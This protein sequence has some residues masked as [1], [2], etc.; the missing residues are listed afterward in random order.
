MIRTTVRLDKIKRLSDTSV[1][2]LKALSDRLGDDSAHVDY[3]EIAS[4]LG[5]PRSSVKYVLD[6]MIQDGVVQIVNGNELSVKDSIVWVE[7]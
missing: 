2:V 1:D 4:S 5:I 3:S 6:R 7:I